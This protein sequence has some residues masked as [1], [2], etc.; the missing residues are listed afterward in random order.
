MLVSANKS[1]QRTVNHKV[2]DRGRDVPALWRA[3]ARSS[4]DK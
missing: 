2:F 4:A 1:L 3:P